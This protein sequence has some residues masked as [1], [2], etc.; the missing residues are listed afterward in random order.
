[1]KVFIER[2]VAFLKRWAIH[3]TPSFDEWK[4]LFKQEK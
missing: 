3:L 1:M 4:E 2:N